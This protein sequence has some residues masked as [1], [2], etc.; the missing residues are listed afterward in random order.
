MRAISSGIASSLETGRRAGDRVQRSPG[1]GDGEGEPR[2]AS[3]RGRIPSCAAKSA[4]DAVPCIPAPVF[5]GH[6]PSTVT[7]ETMRKATP[8]LML[9]VIAAAASCSRSRGAV[10]SPPTA[11]TGDARQVVAEVDG[12]PITRAD[13]DKKAAEPLL[14]LRQRIR[15][16][17][18]LD[19]MIADR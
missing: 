9:A 11:T 1:G 14:A 4:R 17:A 12:A 19:E 3:H 18:A 15:H 2:Q 8:L 10:S 7:W 6:A 16:P 5:D 13:L